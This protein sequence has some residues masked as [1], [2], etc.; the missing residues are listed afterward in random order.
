MSL[1][2]RIPSL[3]PAEHRIEDVAIAAWKA[4]QAIESRESNWTPKKR[5]QLDT[6]WRLDRWQIDRANTWQIVQLPEGFELFSYYGEDST[7]EKIVT[8]ISIRKERWWTSA[9]DNDKFFMLYGYLH[10]LKLNPVD[11][12]SLYVY[13]DKPDIAD[14]EI[15]EEWENM[16]I[17]WMSARGFI[18]RATFIPLDKVTKLIQVQNEIK[19]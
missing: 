18:D 7:A 14:E 10:F 3:N 6:A 13:F 17:E 2:V 5:R 4:L 15:L 19:Y 1:F 9:P 16:H 11:A 12:G 8:M